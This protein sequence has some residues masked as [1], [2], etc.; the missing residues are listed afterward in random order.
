MKWVA[1]TEILVVPKI[2]FSQCRGSS[3]RQ[4]P[5]C[6]WK[7][8]ITKYPLINSVLIVFLIPA[9]TS[10][11]TAR[12]FKGGKLIKKDRTALHPENLEAP[13]FIRYSLRAIGY[14]LDLLPTPPGFVLPNAMC[15]KKLEQGGETVVT[16]RTSSIRST[17]MC[18]Y[19]QWK[20]IVT[21]C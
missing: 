3:I 10:T 6:F 17:K 20:E 5:L 7:Q 8:N 1:T 21:K 13:V 2:I 11:P 16:L 9:P 15:T 14:S 19:Y 12:K 4:N 18:V